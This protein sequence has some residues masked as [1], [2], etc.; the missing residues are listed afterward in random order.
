VQEAR[1]LRTEPRELA[2]E[3]DTGPSQGV[4]G[5]LQWNRQEQSSRETAPYS[6]FQ[7]TAD[8][9]T[10]ETV[11]QS[12]I[13][14]HN[15]S[16]HCCKLEQAIGHVMPWLHVVQCAQLPSGS[17]GPLRICGQLRSN[18]EVCG[19]ARMFLTRRTSARRRQFARSCR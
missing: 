12:L 8:A 16:L 5:R 3:Q 15:M 13:P 4:P 7:E 6:G 14:R 10:A 19:E 17:F 9:V 2:A 11:A 18:N 1:R